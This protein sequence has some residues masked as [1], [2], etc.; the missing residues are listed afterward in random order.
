MFALPFST[1]LPADIQPNKRPRRA[2]QTVT[3]YAP[4]CE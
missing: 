4:G 1:T 2:A 3:K